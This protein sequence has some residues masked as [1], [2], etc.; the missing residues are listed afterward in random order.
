[1]PLVKATLSSNILSVFTKMKNQAGQQGFDGDKEFS[2]GLAKAFKDFG[3]SGS[4]TTTD[5]GT[6]PSG[7]YIG[8][9]TGSLKLDDTS[10]KQTL[11]TACHKMKNN[12]KDDDYLAEQI[13]S[14]LSDM[15][16]ASNVVETKSSGSAT[17]PSGVVTPIVN[18]S[19][20]GTITISFAV[21]ETSLKAYF[22]Q[23]KQDGENGATVTDNALA[24]KIADLLYTA[25]KSGVVNTQGS[26]DTSGGVGVG[27]IT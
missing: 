10:C 5:S 20:K 15:Y 6:I 24:N 13:A 8:A 19:W 23:M 22:A 1:M 9:G 25:V 4:I 27:T 2:D 11:L 21:F 18:A 17:N 12:H 14:A 7:V 26:G 3:E 16:G